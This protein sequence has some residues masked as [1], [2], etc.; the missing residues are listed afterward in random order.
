M[1][2]VGSFAGGLS[3]GLTSGWALGKDI[4]ERIPL[5][6]ARDK[7][8]AELA[9]KQSDSALPSVAAKAPSVNDPDTPGPAGLSAGQTNLTADGYDPNQT[10][11]PAKTTGGRVATGA[12]PAALTPPWQSQID[13]SKVPDYYSPAAK[14]FQPEVLTRPSTAATSPALPTAAPEELAPPLVA[15]PESTMQLPGRGN[16]APV[17]A[18]PAV[19]APTMPI[20]QWWNSTFGAPPITGT[21]AGGGRGRERLPYLP[22]PAI[23]SGPPIA[24]GGRGNYD[25]A[26]VSPG[27]SAPPSSGWMPV[28]PSHPVPPTQIDPNTGQPIQQAIPFI[29]A[30]Y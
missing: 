15:Q 17:P 10:Y 18:G 19:P 24:L 2:M 30:P 3:E 7:A 5:I 26:A 9:K 16:Y 12:T 27:R 6:E 20:K 4:Q 23:P 22:T 21:P 14:G 1:F 29:A 8:R 25:P 11:E 13:T 28:A